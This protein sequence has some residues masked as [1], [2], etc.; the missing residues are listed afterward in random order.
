MSSL[1]NNYSR[2]NLTL[3]KGEGAWL[4]DA[5]G[6]RYLDAL[7]GVA[8]CGLGHCHP[9]VTKAMQEQAATL[10]HSS[11]IYHVAAQEKLADTLVRLS[12][13]TNA[14]FNNSGAEANETAIKLA[15][16]Y[17]HKK[18]ITTPAIIV[19]DNSFHGRTL[20]TLTATGNRKIQAGFEPL[21]QGF[22]RAPYND[23]DAVRNIAHNTNDVV[24]IFVEPVQGEGGIR[25][26]DANYLAEL[27]K[28][29]D[30]HDWLLMLDEIQTSVCRTGKWFAFQHSDC[31]PDV[32]TLA[33]NLANGVPIGACLA[34]DKAADLFKPGNHGSTFGG[35][36][37][38]CTVASAALAVYEKENLAERAATLGQYIVEELRTSLQNLSGLVEIR[39]KGMMIGLELDR[40]CGNL[41]KDAIDRG[42]LINVTADKVI[43]LLPPMT[44]SDAEADQLITILS[45]LVKDFLAQQSAA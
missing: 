2:Q 23:L 24:A 45:T 36:P 43:R 25:I 26:P 35:S 39:G 32:M 30:E 15:R 14:F 34:G 29:C 3:V 4:I 42:L 9:E 28:I 17:G 31:K 21:V 38:A 6:N 18:G 10:V 40:P 5:A 13:L 22:I 16:L 44:L 7:S 8:V 11:N 1:M 33:K 20:A 27:R 41:V 19:M 37:F 12:G